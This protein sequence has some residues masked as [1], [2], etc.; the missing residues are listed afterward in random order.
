FRR[1]EA[2]GAGGIGAPDRADGPRQAGQGRADPRAGRGAAVRGRAPT[3]RRRASRRGREISEAEIERLLEQQ[4]LPAWFTEAELA[5]L[6]E[7]NAAD[8]AFLARPRE[9]PP[10]SFVQWA[11]DDE[12]PTRRIIDRTR[13]ALI[14]KQ[15]AALT[16]M[17]K[18]WGVAKPQL[19]AAEYLAARH[20]PSVRKEGRRL[21]NSGGALLA[22]LRRTAIV[23]L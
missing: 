3:R 19:R 23:F 20:R 9:G 1:R 21:F 2:A 14:R 13:A 6:G 17:L 8:S 7:A 11:R 10:G 12:A 18:A 4:P 15:L 5:E 22:W 16:P